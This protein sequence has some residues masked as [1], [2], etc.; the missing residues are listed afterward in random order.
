[1]TFRDFK[2]FNPKMFLR[3]VQMRCDEK[4]FNSINGLNE[5]WQSFKKAFVSVCDVHA[6][7]C[8]RRLKHRH[9]PWIDSNIVSMMYHRDYIKQKAVKLKDENLFNEI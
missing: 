2:K 4:V 1:M 7:M 3:D 6:P 9:N 5:K 8:T